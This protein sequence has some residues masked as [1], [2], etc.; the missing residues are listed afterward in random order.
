MSHVTPSEFAALE[1]VAQERARMLAVLAPR[2]PSITARLQ[3]PATTQPL[4][5]SL[6]HVVSAY[7]VGLS[8]ALLAGLY[9]P[10]PLVRLVSFV[11]A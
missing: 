7:V 11:I 4:R 3:G 5:P 2:A 1:V 9:L 6:L 8:C 10:A